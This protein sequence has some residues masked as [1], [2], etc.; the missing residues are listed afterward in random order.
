[1]HP[2]GHLPKTDPIVYPD[3]NFHPSPSPRPRW[4]C[5]PHLK[6]GL[7]RAQEHRAYTFEARVPIMHTAHKC[8]QRR[9]KLLRKHTTA[10]MP[11]LWQPIATP[12]TRPEGMA[13]TWP[14]AS[15]LP[16]KTSGG[17]LALNHLFRQGICVCSQWRRWQRWQRRWCFGCTKM[18][19]WPSR[20]PW[21][22]P[23]QIDDVVL[24]G[25]GSYQSCFVVG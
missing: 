6:R 18:V 5:Y 23:R 2:T 19:S 3:H 9:A 24:S 14:P 10:K 22:T 4:L 1:M 7:P 12:T 15:L 20:C 17:P 13:D 11:K 8:Q 25:P 16:L 21:H